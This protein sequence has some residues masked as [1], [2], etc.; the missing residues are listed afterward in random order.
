MS[1]VEEAL[2]NPGSG[3]SQASGFAASLPLGD[4]AAAT[5]EYKEET[6]KTIGD[7]RE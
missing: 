4:P 2:L 3:P 7:D 1:V 6:S 5:R